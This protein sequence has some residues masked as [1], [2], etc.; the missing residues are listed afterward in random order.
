M[1]VPDILIERL[2]NAQYVAVLTGAGVSA[3]SGIKTFRDPDGL[4]AKLNPAELASVDGFMANP[5]MVWEW[6]QHRREIIHSS[7]PNPGHYAMAEMQKL[8]PKFTLITQNVDRLHQQAGSTNVVELHGNIIENHCFNCSKPYIEEVN[9]SDSK[10]PACTY[11]NGRIRPS[12]VWF[13]EMLPEDAIEQAQDTAEN[14]DLFFCAGTSA[15]VYPAANIPILAKQS[16]A[17]VV[18]V[19]PN[20]TVLSNYVDLKLAYPSG[21]AFPAI[22][23]KLK[24]L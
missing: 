11:C 9:V 15:E 16:G 18:E 10:L 1:D 17:F 7:K 12:V 8:F 3:E 5:Q 23:E 14:C 4:W 21:V 22:V 6:Y 13:G 24:Q 2:K 20:D 19:N